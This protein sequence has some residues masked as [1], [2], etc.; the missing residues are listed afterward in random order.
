MKGKDGDLRLE[1]RCLAYIILRYHVRTMK[2][3]YDFFNAVKVQE[4]YLSF[5]NLIITFILSYL[6]SSWNVCRHIVT[7]IFL[8]EISF[9]FKEIDFLSY[10]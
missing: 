8:L 4:Y 7:D 6:T 9:S 3:S 1:V 10:L 2:A 5:V